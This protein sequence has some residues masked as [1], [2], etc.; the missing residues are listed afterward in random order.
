[1]IIFFSLG[2][3]LM[4]GILALCITKSKVLMQKKSK[5]FAEKISAHITMIAGIAIILM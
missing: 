3:G 5:E 4:L 1:M 2:L